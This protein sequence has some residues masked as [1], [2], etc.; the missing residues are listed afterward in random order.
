MALEV[1]KEHYG[2]NAFH[3]HARRDL[4][5]RSRYR[6]SQAPELRPAQKSGHPISPVFTRHNDPRL[7]DWATESLYNGFIGG[8][9]A[10]FDDIVY[11]PPKLKEGHFYRSYE[12]FG[13]FLGYVSTKMDPDPDLAILADGRMRAK[14][15]P[16]LYEW[17]ASQ[18]FALPSDQYEALRGRA[19]P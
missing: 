1:A 12:Q 8:R 10:A 4:H 19:K 17:L 5:D 7:P 14:T 15:M 2:V 3:W 9:N 11:W 13:H 6:A 16:E 18:V